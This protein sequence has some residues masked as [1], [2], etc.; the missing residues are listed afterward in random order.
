MTNELQPPNKSTGQLFTKEVKKEQQQQI[1]G[2]NKLTKF[3]WSE[4][5][6]VKRWIIPFRISRGAN[7]VLYFTFSPFS[8]DVLSFCGEK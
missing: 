4:S 1:A 3:N 7:A 6:F 8:T 5:F 2:D